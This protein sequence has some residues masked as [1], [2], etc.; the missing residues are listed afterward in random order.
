MV[1]LW[2]EL[3][4]DLAIMLAATSVY[5][6]VFVVLT[7]YHDPVGR[8]LHKYARINPGM[9]RSLLRFCAYAYPVTVVVVLLILNLTGL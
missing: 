7:E 2:L 3:L 6:G 5:T 9:Q 8:M 4:W 1:K